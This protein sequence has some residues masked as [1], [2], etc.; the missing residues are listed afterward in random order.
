MLRA[1]GLSET[2]TY[3]FADPRDLA[4][5]GMSEE[6]KGVPV[7]IMRPLVADQSEMRRDIIPGLLRAVAYNIDHGVANVHLYEIGRVFYGHELKSLPRETRMVAA[8]MSGAWDDKSWCSAP[9]AFDFFDAKG[10]VEQLLRALRIEKVRFQ[11]AD[12]DACGWLQPGNAAQVLIG[13]QP[14]GWVGA[15]H[16]LSLQKF[17]VD[18]PV[19]AFELSFDELVR[20]AHKELAYTE[21]PTLPG[22]SLDLAIV[23]PE[24]LGYESIM[25]RIRSAGGKLLSEVRLFD[26]YRDDVRVGVGKKSMAFALTYRADDHTLTSQEVDKAHKKLIEKI[27]RS[28]KAEIRS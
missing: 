12:P 5:L 16:P 26:M 1:Q 2:V 15:I 18:T 22:V 25:Q 28:C 13:G 11:P 8:V 27:S 9:S 6:G 7:R 23:V 20:N 3:N 21:V 10:I 24:E 19:F 17:G 14:A 4:Q